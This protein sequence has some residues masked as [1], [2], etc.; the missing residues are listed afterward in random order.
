MNVIRPKTLEEALGFL[1]PAPAIRAA[2]GGTDLIPRL[3]QKFESCDTLCLLGDFPE[4]TGVR[5]EA[6]D[7]IF[8]GAM[9]TLSGV[10]REPLLLPYTALQAAAGG[11]ASPQIRNRATVGGNI[12]QENRCLYFNNQI[13]WSDVTRCYK[14]GGDKCF[15][16]P[17]SRVCMALFQSDLAP[18]L[19][20][21]GAFVRIAGVEGAAAEDA[22]EECLNAERPCGGQ[23]KTEKPGE[24]L[25]GRGVIYREMPVSDLYGA[26]GRKNLEAGELVAGVLIPERGP[27]EKCVYERWALRRSFDFPLLSCA[28]DVKPSGREVR[29]VFGSAGV[30]PRRFTAGE[31]AFAGQPAKALPEIARGLSDR[32]AAVIMPF[33]D[34]HVDGETRRAMAG[35]LLERA[36]ERLAAGE[37]LE[38]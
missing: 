27:G 5:K 11:A 4:M 14:R 17:G 33:G 18:V 29:I 12:L 20:A 13:P 7:R 22:C 30:R 21:Y 9:T 3:N 1:A 2:A 32:A 34:T 38:R 6:G 8:V 31:E 24:D 25:S 36:A 35:T 15:Q 10:S 23:P 26:G 37:W 16:Y 19:M 28:I